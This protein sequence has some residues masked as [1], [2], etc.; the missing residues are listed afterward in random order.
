MTPDAGEVVMVVGDRARILA[1]AASTAG[2][3]AMFE[4]VTPPGIGPPLHRHE[5]E[6]ETFYVCEGTVKFSMDGKVFIAGPGSFVVA[7][8]GSTHTFV[9]AGAQPSRM[10]VSVMPA[11][12]EEAFRA[13]AAMFA[14]NPSA[15]PAEMAELFGRYGVTFH[16]PPLDPAV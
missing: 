8:R 1:D 2:R 10:I 4:I 16:G 12:F 5:R 6:D 9:N 3:C 13:C 11:G 15:G 7:P 14:K